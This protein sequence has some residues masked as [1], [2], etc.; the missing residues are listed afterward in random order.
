MQHRSM[1]MK[2]DADLLTAIL[3]KI[4]ESKD[5]WVSLGFDLF[6]GHSRQSILHHMELHIDKQHIVTHGEVAQGDS[7]DVYPVKV[8]MT[9]AG[10]DWLEKSR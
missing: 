10:H 8:R 2:R 5:S 6:P 4:E 9:W 3:N 1:T 7:G